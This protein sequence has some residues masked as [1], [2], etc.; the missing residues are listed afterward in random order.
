M[1][2]APSPLYH[3]ALDAIHASGCLDA[4]RKPPANERSLVHARHMLSAL[5]DATFDNPSTAHTA[6]RLFNPEALAR[7]IQRSWNDISPEQALRDA[8]R[9][10]MV[11]AQPD[12]REAA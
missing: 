4:H 5:V 1:P 6:L 12:E 10:P 7:Y 9:A 3:A 2:L 8:A 11:A